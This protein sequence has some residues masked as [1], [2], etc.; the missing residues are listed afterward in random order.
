M[1]RRLDPLNSLKHLIIIST[2]RNNSALNKSTWGVITSAVH[3]PLVVV[4]LAFKNSKK[5]KGQCD[6]G[7]DVEFADP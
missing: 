7:P 3:N 2:A 1:Y 6:R 4:V 5:K